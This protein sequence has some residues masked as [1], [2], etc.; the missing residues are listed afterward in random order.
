MLHHYGWVK[1][2]GSVRGS[3]GAYLTTVEARKKG[4]AI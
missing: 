1:A 2:D 3:G 4:L